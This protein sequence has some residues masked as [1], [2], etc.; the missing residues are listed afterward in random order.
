VLCSAPES[1]VATDR[2]AR[3]QFGLY[4]VEW[5]DEDGPSIEF[6]LPHGEMIRVLREAGF[7]VEALHELRPPAD[8]TTTYEWVSLE[9][10]RSWPTEEI[11]V[12]RKR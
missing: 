6:H 2:L 5:N 7:E 9:W 12:T 3:P 10:A 4:Q 11:W 1:E 8:A